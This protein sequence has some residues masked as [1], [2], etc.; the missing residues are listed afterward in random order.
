VQC[1][2]RRDRDQRPQAWSCNGSSRWPIRVAR[3][4]SADLE[5][6]AR[7]RACSWLLVLLV[8]WANSR[9]ALVSAVAFPVAPD[10]QHHVLRSQASS[11]ST[12]S[13]CRHGCSPPTL[14]DDPL[15]VSEDMVGG[16]EAGEC[17]DAGRPQCMQ[18]N[19]GCVIATSWCWW[20]SSCR[21]LAS[22][23]VSAGFT[24]RFA[25]TICAT[26]LFSTLQRPHLLLPWLPAGLVSAMAKEPD[27]WSRCC[28]PPTLAGPLRHWYGKALRTQLSRRRLVAASDYSAGLCW[29]AGRLPA[30]NRLH[31]P[32]RRQPGAR[33]RG[34]PRCAPHCAAPRGCWEKVG[35]WW[36]KKKLCGFGKLRTPALLRRQRPKQSI[37]LPA[38][39]KPLE[40]AGNAKGKQQRS[41]SPTAGAAIARNRSPRA[42]GAV[43]ALPVRGSAARG[44]GARTADT[45]AAGSIFQRTSRP[46]CG[47]SSQRPTPPTPFERVSTRF[48]ATTPCCG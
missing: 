38:P 14:V 35:R 21:C 1:L 3:K 4:H 23:Q 39:N 48:S 13:P 43:S 22:R 2:P 18:E 30:A 45:A 25:I 15:F 9:L 27:C 33:R 32:R 42:T 11:I 24:N 46:R 5:Q 10:W 6:L 29:R 36:P 31:P 34:A 47:A 26:I 12:R 19:W 8:P 28:S 7:L 41:H 37:L 44:A 17:A 40:Q 20:C 16:L